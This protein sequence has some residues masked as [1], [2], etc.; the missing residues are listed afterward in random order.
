VS[1]RRGSQEVFAQTGFVVMVRADDLAQIIYCSSGREPTHGIVDGAVD[2]IAVT[3]HIYG[4]PK[5]G[6]VMAD[7]LAGIVDAVGTR[8]VAAQR[9]V[10]RGVDAVAVEKAVRSVRGSRDVVPNDLA[11]IVDAGGNGEVTGGQ[12]IIES[13]VNPM[14]VKEAVNA[15]SVGVSA[16]DLAAVSAGLGGGQIASSSNQPH[17]AEDRYRASWSRLNFTCG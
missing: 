7:D 1:V 17:M 2:A 8:A 10:N 6:L 15:G 11:P 12:R 9:V 3:K 16:D 14:A 4:P 5:Q 13:S